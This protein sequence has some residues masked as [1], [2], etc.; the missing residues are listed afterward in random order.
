MAVMIDISTPKFC[1]SWIDSPPVWKSINREPF[2]GIPFSANTFAT[3]RREFLRLNF[4]TLILE[5]GNSGTR[6]PGAE[7]PYPTDRDDASV[8]LIGRTSGP[9]GGG[10]WVALAATSLPA[11]G[12]H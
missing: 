10:V 5:S 6:H 2:S 4:D 8:A 7:F 9:G 1:V 11:P 3:F 12:R